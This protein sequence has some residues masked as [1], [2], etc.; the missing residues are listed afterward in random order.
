[1]FRLSTWLLRIYAQNMYNSFFSKSCNRQVSKTYAITIFFTHLFMCIN[2]FLQK[3][4]VIGAVI[5][6]MYKPWTKWSASGYM[7]GPV[8]IWVAVCKCVFRRGQM[9][10][11]T[12]ST[13]RTKGGRAFSTKLSLCLLALELNSISNTKHR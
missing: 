4:G 5:D 9:L 11:S 6:S 8:G 2:R 10:A 13:P 3:F 7:T 12:P 1:M